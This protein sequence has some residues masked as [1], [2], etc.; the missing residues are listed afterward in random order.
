MVCFQTWTDTRI[1][2]PAVKPFQL[3]SRD[4]NF[5]I[6]FLIGVTV[7]YQHSLWTGAVDWV[8][9]LSAI[10]FNYIYIYLVVSF[11]ITVW[12][13]SSA[14]HELAGCVAVQLPKHSEFL[15][16]RR[17]RLRYTISAYT[18]ASSQLLYVKRTL[19]IKCCR[20]GCAHECRG[21]SQPLIRIDF[22]TVQI[23][24]IKSAV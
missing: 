12:S 6:I 7:L 23:F 21:W 2:S 1:A 20:H 8:D 3:Q 16:F 10:K 24:G 4:F 14:A 9:W 18:S 5:L 11:L 13:P 17:I 15:N 22:I 19:S